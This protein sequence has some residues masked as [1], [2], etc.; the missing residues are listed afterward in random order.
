MIRLILVR[1]GQTIKNVK[2]EAQGHSDSHITPEGMLQIQKTRDF[3]KDM[4]IDAI[5]CSNLARA[6]MSAEIIGAPH[7][8]RPVI[9][10]ELKELD[11]GEFDRYST[12]ELPE[13][14][15]RY[16]EDEKRKGVNR[17]DIRPSKGENS[18]DHMKRIRCILDKIRENYKDKT[19][20]I[21]GHSGTNKVIIGLL[22]EV[23]PEE[24]YTVIQDNACIN[25]LDLDDRGKLV[26]AEINITKHLS[27]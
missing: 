11:W 21:V 4:H 12:K 17:E 13:K 10:E 8:I 2:N 7:H 6:I 9:S 22:R 27:G 1:H 19:V 20:L 15:S 3:L 25:I 14:W 26:N 24:F 18:F 5:I 23:D 16:F